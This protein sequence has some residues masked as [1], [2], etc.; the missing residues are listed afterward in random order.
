MSSGGNLPYQ[1][2][3]N[4]AVE[5]LLFAELLN[6]LDPRLR[7]GSDYEYFGFGGPQMEDFRLLNECFPKMKML[8]VE[9]EVQVLKR[10]RFNRPH[11]NVRCKHQTSLDFVSSFQTRTKAVVWLDYTEPTERRTQVTEFQHLLRR[12]QQGRAL[13][14]RGRPAGP[15][16]SRRLAP[17][18]QGPAQAGDGGGGQTRHRGL[19]RSPLAVGSLA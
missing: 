8:S 18:A 4:K 7:I 15:V 9:R 5:R 17:E 13:R 6:R 11:T 19:R 14:D 3:P 2:R 12:V 10:Q 16:H 1:L